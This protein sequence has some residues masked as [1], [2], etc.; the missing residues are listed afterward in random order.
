MSLQP[1]QQ[2][3]WRGDARRP[4]FPSPVAART[5]RA[6]LGHSPRLRTPPTKSRTAH[7]RVG[8]GHRART[9]N[10][11]LNSHPSISNPVVLSLCATSRRTWPSSRARPV[12]PGH[13]NV[14]KGIVREAGELTIA[15]AA[16]RSPGDDNPR[17]PLVAEALAGRASVPTQKRSRGR[18]FRD[19]STPATP[20]RMDSRGSDHDRQLAPGLHAA[21]AQVRLPRLCETVENSRN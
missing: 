15:F 20:W 18:F 11:P 14:A 17:H 4:I 13:S 12:R 6:A 2:E 19:G 1:P 10:Y 9:W 8:T 5:E 21:N 3:G 7:A 16:E